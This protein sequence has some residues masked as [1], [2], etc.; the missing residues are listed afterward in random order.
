MS[1][2]AHWLTNMFERKQAILHA[3]SF[4]GTHTGN[5]IREKFES[6]LQ[7]WGISKE[8]LSLSCSSRQWQ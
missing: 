5:V 3:E 8:Q 6:M 4:E 1:L 2:T 7:R